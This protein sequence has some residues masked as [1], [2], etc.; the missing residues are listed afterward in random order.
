MQDIEVMRLRSRL[1]KAGFTNISIKR[2]CFCG[3]CYYYVSAKYHEN[4]FKKS[5]YYDELK[6]HP[7]KVQ[8]YIL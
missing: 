6:Y 1:Y 3:E 4:F 7:Q 8:Y 2:V 5:L